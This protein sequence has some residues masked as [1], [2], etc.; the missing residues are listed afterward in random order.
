M[1]DLAGLD[2]S[3]ESSSQKSSRANYNYN[4]N[5][6]SLSTSTLKPTPPASGRATPL[7]NPSSLPPS[8]PATPANDSFANLVSWSGSASN[9]NLSLQEQQKRL[10]DLKI[11]QTKVTST[12]N[13]TGDEA[14]WTNLESGR[15]SPAVTSQKNGNGSGIASKR[16]QEEDDIFAAFNAPGTEFKKTISTSHPQKQGPSQEDDDPF[17]LSEIQHKSTQRTDTS[18]IM[19]T[20]DDDD[21]LGLLGR[22]VDRNK[23]RPDLD[24]AVSEPRH[25]SDVHPQEA[26][27]AE[28]VDM[29]FP[30]DKA[31]RAL[32]TTDSG[33]DVQAAVGFLLNSAHQEARDRSRNQDPS[34]NDRH[35]EH[36]QR[37]DPRRNPPSRRHAADDEDLGA[38]RR[39]QQDTEKDPSQIAAEIGSNFFKTANSFWKQSTKK[40][41]QAMQEF[42]SDSDTGGQ[43]KWM[44]ET[45]NDRPRS[46]A[47]REDEQAGSRRQRS[48]AG[49][50]K[51]EANV[52]DEAMMLEAQRPTPP[53]SRQ[54]QRRP[55]DRF[56]SS[57]DASRDH[58]PAVPS[59]LRESASP[60]PAF[61]RQ[62]PKQA[63]PATSS[64]T[65]L[66]RQANEDQAAQAYV[67]SARRR[68]PAAAAASEPG[69]F[70]VSEQA[71]PQ[72]PASSRPA[73]KVP[74]KPTPIATRPPPP[75]R[76][77]PTIPPLSLKASH[78]AR[79]AG[80]A[81]FKRGDYSSAH[82]SY[83]T[84]LN[85]LPKG[86]PLTL[87]LLT[88][89]A[90]TALKIG[91]PKTAIADS[92]I[93]ITLIGGS[94]GESESIDFGDGSPAK[95]MRD[96][97]GKAIMRKAE[98]L[99]QMEKWAEAATVWKEAVEAGHGGAASM[100]G[101]LRAERAANPPPK[102]KPKPASAI[103][104][105]R[106]A[107][108]RGA[109]AGTAS[110]DSAAVSRLR[111]ANA[112]A[113]RAD[114]EKFALGDAVDARINTWR[115]GKQDNLRA[116]LGSLD[117]VLWPE[118]GWKKISMAD[119]VLP[120]KVKIQYM[121]GI[122]KVHPDK[123]SLWQ[124]SLF[125]VSSMV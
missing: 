37:M 121:K 82:S 102:P 30:A 113:D 50:A 90:L 1:D 21:V 47:N 17:G 107:P 7:N 42:N 88:N 16:M 9:A 97:Y 40:V 92:D 55:D 48:S 29:G 12:Q 52:T 72:R 4:F 124:I 57:A 49:K 93:A 34:A 41:Q 95:P 112:A 109:A 69:I 115:N 46:S 78:T 116:L 111:A 26:A 13:G 80:N 120:G 105:V 70:I 106:K 53:P 39:K 28:L 51:E 85:H 96:Y 24:V 94:K 36:P 33:T 14:F 25:K 125:R 59:R 87:V 117:T 61:L 23:P 67:S 104:A 100:Q 38:R 11:Q 58:S 10:A 65:A 35:D 31:R 19:S 123:V 119:L 45:A 6:S 98:A 84:S 44:R 79:E 27:V 101:R 103:P 15:G 77:I 60:Q 8:K 71:A 54:T 110:A 118:A 81:H 32:E 76:N 22:P 2:W 66:S 75:K 83:N 86:H 89:H 108:A 18:M 3:K 68:K 122:G 43:P 5:P 56:D 91:E 74:P 73:P 63:Q 20:N 114:D 62:Q 99:E 64:R